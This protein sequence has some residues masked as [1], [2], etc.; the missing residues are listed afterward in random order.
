GQGQSVPADRL[1]WKSVAGSHS[2]GWVTT[3]WFDLADGEHDGYGRL[4]DPVTHRRVVFFLK[5]DVWVIWDDLRSRGRHDL[6]FLLHLRPDCRVDVDPGSASFV[7]TS[8]NGSRLTAWISGAGDEVEVL[9]GTERERGAWFSPGYGTRVPSRA[10]R[11][12]RDFTGQGGLVTCLSISEQSR[13]VVTQHD[14]AI[15]CRVN[16]AGGC[17]ERLFYRTD[18]GRASLAEGIHFDG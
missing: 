12:T 5:P 7:L 8:P 18:A 6:E 11:V 3:R 17:E 4:S 2:R 1:S 9:T 10:L 13:P 14:G 16:R 15:E